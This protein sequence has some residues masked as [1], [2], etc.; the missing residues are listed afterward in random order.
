MRIWRAAVWGLDFITIGLFSM[1]AGSAPLI[2]IDML[3]S[4]IALV[5]LVT[6]GVLLGLAWLM[7][8][9]LWQAAGGDE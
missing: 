8:V 3:R 2:H 5:R 7:F 9:P 4:Y 1:T 6:L